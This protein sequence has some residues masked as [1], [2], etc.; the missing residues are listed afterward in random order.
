M[1][2]WEKLECEVC[3]SKLPKKM[4]IGENIVELVAL[5]RPEGPY[6]IL[7]ST[8]KEAKIEGKNLYILEFKN[9]DTLKLVTFVNDVYLMFI[10]VED[11]N[12]KQGY[13]I[14]LYQDTI[15]T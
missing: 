4:K 10:R 13:Q 8:S 1:I 2:S 14:F 6:I 9:Y 15:P 3:K 12:V 11:I 5:K 7:E